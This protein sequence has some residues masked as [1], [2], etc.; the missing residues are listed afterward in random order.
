MAAAPTL[1][2][3]QTTDPNL[4]QVQLNVKAALGAFLPLAGGT[5]SG[6]VVFAPGQSFPSTQVTIGDPAYPHV[7]IHRTLADH[8]ADPTIHRQPGPPLVH[9]A[10]HE[11]GGGDMLFGDQIAINAANN[12]QSI[13][14][15]VDAAVAAVG[16]PTAGFAPATRYAISGADPLYASSIAINAS[17]QTTDVVSYVNAQIAAQVASGGGGV[18][19]SYTSVTITGAAGLTFT[20]PFKITSVGNKI[21][22]SGDGTNLFI[23]PAGASGV[24]NLGTQTSSSAYG[25]FSANGYAIGGTSIGGSSGTI[26]GALSVQGDLVVSR[27]SLTAPTVGE[28]QFGI[29][30][31]AVISYNADVA[32]AFYVSAPITFSKA[33][34][35]AAGGSITFAGGIVVAG[36]AQNQA[37]AGIR[38]DGTLLSIYAKDGS[39]IL[40]GVDNVSLTSIQY[41]PGGAWG[42]LNATGWHSGATNLSATG[43]TIGGSL[44]A[45]GALISAQAPAAGQLLLGSSGGAG[46]LDF[47]DTANGVFTFSI[48]GTSK[49]QVAADGSL[50]LVGTSTSYGPAL[51]T[52]VGNVAASR[53]ISAGLGTTYNG[54]SG[55]SFAGV[56]DT[57]VFSSGEGDLRLVVANTVALDI[58]A[59][60][61]TVNEN[62]VATGSIAANTM[63]TVGALSV[64]TDLTI[65]KRLF[66]GGSTITKF[67]VK[68]HIDLGYI[69]GTVATSSIYPNKVIV[70]YVGGTIDAIRLS[71]VTADTT[72]TQT[73]F[74]ILLNGAVIGTVT[75]GNGATTAL[76]YPV[77]NPQPIAAGDQLHCV[78]TSAGTATGALIT[79]ELSQFLI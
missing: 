47:G 3:V 49:L 69:A 10:S 15:Y 34:N 58:S 61:I 2:L 19:P 63:S 57:G 36:T 41:G 12:T 21:V 37:Q 22:L 74:N 71:V 53:N 5:L 62:L 17:N 28:V 35:L 70:G 31:G 27:Q 18:N 48:A 45:N 25:T 7:G 66:A 38:S 59:T 33:I 14:S 73:A 43:A 51:A 77:T 46:G 65:T 40:L 13:K 8:L 4:T 26:G 79:I 67:R 11:L 42:T 52:V 76:A 44:T 1:Q 64:G 72:S 6:P 30:T 78:C 50:V 68:G 55:F 54:T 32:N 75:L 9:A 24:I 60:L 39:S 20:S 56:T 16:T 23:S 29:G